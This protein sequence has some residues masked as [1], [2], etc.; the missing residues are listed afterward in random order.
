MNTTACA[1]DGQHSDKI[2]ERYKR[3][4]GERAIVD[5][6]KKSLE[7][8]LSNIIIGP[9]GQSVPHVQAAAYNV[10]LRLQQSGDIDL[11]YINVTYVSMPPLREV[12]LRDRGLKPGDPVI[13]D[14]GGRHE[15]YY[16]IV[17]S[18]DSD[19]NAVVLSAKDDGIIDVEVNVRLLL[20]TVSDYVKF[21]IELP[22]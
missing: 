18:I 1:V 14:I 6:I 21:N 22:C 7:S 9:H 8:Y 10:L 5:N 16:G 12:D 4:P 20:L 17:V 3:V 13:N 19:G 15:S 2:I 11:F